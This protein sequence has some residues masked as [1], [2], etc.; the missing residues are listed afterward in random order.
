MDSKER[1]KASLQAR[2]RPETSF[3]KKWELGEK[4]GLVKRERER[5]RE[6][7]ALL[8]RLQIEIYDS[9]ARKELALWTNWE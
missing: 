7:S 6:L 5:Q 9:L 1:G 3:V 8:S 4:V 2:T